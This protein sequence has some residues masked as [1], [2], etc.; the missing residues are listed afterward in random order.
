MPQK[1]VGIFVPESTK[2]SPCWSG[3]SPWSLSEPHLPP[4]PAKVIFTE[5]SCDNFYNSCPWINSQTSIEIYENTYT[6]HVYIYYYDCII[7]IIIIGTNN[8]SVACYWDGFHNVQKNWMFHWTSSNPVHILRPMNLPCV[9]SRDVYTPKTLEHNF[10]VP[11]FKSWQI[12]VAKS[13]LSF[14]AF[15]F[16][17]LNIE[18]LLLG[19]EFDMFQRFCLELSGSIAQGLGPWDSDT[20]DS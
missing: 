17:R 7:I 10:F 14:W 19:L 6:I 15:A 3:L 20:I 5:T 13:H 1:T 9:L 4:R 18:D 16:Q 11:R 12:R 2:Q 8:H